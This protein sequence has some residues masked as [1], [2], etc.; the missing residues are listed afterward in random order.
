MSY[1]FEILSRHSVINLLCQ[2]CSRIQTFY[3]STEICPVVSQ[4]V[5]HAHCPIFADPVTN[6]TIVFAIKLPSRNQ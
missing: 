6:I 2:K 5:V 1:G 4:D 3:S